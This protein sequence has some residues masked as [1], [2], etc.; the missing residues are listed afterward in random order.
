MR[1]FISVNNLHLRCL[2]NPHNIARCTERV[3]TY[4]M[5]SL[6]TTFTILKCKDVQATVG[7]F[8]FPFLPNEF[9]PTRPEQTA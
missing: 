5:Q 2:K 7:L 4:S 3:K 6:S 1:Q 9:G 8:L